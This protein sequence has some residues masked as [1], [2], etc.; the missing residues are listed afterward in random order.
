MN[1]KYILYAMAM[2]IVGQS[3]AWFQFNGP[4]LW[5]WAKQFKYIILILGIPVSW[6][7]MEATSTAVTGFDGQLWP[8]RFLSFVSGMFVFSVLTYMFKSE[9]ITAKTMICLALSFAIICIQVFWK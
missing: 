8:S 3:M 5:G 4:I 1:Y 2:F 6:F 7:F 9:P